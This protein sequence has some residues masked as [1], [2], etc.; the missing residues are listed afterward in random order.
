MTAPPRSHWIHVHASAQGE[1]EFIR[2][3]SL[4]GCL[5]LP[6]APQ[7]LNKTYKQADE[8]ASRFM[9]SALGQVTAWL[10]R[11]PGGS[12]CTQFRNNK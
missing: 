4:L 2:L 3:R 1:A 10:H 12:I 6:A 9:A 5:F 7:M 11:V 8:A